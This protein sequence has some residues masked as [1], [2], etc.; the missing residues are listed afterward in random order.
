[1]STY[2]KCE[3]SHNSQVLRFNMLI[4]ECEA[5]LASLCQLPYRVVMVGIPLAS[6]MTRAPL[7]PNAL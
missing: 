5:F 6:S 4:G 2:S 3:A 1:M 7:R